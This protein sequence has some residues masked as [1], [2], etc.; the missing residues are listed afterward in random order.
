VATII[1]GFLSI[2]GSIKT[3]DRGIEFMICIKS[4]I[5]VMLTALLASGCTQTVVDVTNSQKPKYMDVAG[6]AYVT[7]ASFFL[8]TDRGAKR[9][10][11]FGSDRQN[12][13]YD[14]AN[15]TGEEIHVAW[16]KNSFI[17]DV[18]DLGTSLHVD[19]IEYVAGPTM[20]WD[21]IYGR[22]LTGRHAGETVQIEDLFHQSDRPEISIRPRVD[23]LK[24]VERD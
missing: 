15:F 6:K 14:P 16:G 18:I 22:F 11:L 5:F 23:C 12:F 8:V 2:A 3:N 17:T 19:R 7:E 10:Y 9:S 21:R 1:L 24:E 20:A 4:K 13:P